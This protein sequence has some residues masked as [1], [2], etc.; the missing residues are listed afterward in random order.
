MIYSPSPPNIRTMRRA[1]SLLC[2]LVATLPAW[3]TPLATPHNCT[4]VLNQEALW[5]HLQDFLRRH[6]Q[7]KDLLS[8]HI[9]QSSVRFLQKSGK[10]KR[11]RQT[12]RAQRSHRFCAISLILG[13]KVLLKSKV[14]IIKGSVLSFRNHPSC[15]SLTQKKKKEV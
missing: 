4:L 7:C 15:S 13:C 11:K 2:S 5:R 6:S 8:S 14:N 9:P 12:F 10:I 3:V 1:L